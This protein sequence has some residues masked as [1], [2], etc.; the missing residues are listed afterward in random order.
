MAGRN[1]IYWGGLGGFGVWRTLR[2][3][4]G[5]YVGIGGCV[6]ETIMAEEEMIHGMQDHGRMDLSAMYLHRQPF[7]S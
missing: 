6:V 5:G 2:R 1:G 7:V 4:F 3:E